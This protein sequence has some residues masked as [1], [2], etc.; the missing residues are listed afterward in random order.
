M[1][2]ECAEI[3]TGFLATISYAKFAAT[4]PEHLQEQANEILKSTYLE[5]EITERVNQSKKGAL[6][7]SGQTTALG[8]FLR[9]GPQRASGVRIVS[10][11][12]CCCIEP[13]KA[14]VILI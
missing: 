1:K 3:S 5:T 6:G 9:I 8:T 10:L 4:L 11:R 7:L 12:P 14:S 13:R 2:F